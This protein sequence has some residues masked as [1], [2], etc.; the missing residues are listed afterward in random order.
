M[1]W[2]SCSFICASCSTRVALSKAQSL[3]PKPYNKPK[4]FLGAFFVPP[5]SLGSQ[6]TAIHAATAS[7]AAAAAAN[8]M[9]GHSPQAHVGL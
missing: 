1:K 6:A 8:A 4:P 9:L 5:T 2:V 3:N 7:A